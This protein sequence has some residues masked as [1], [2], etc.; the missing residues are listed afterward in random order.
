M[1]LPRLI[2]KPGNVVPAYAATCQQQF[3][4]TEEAHSYLVINVNY[5]CN[6]KLLFFSIPTVSGRRMLKRYDP[7]KNYTPHCPL[8]IQT[9]YVPPGMKEQW[10]RDSPMV[11]TWPP[12]VL[13]KEL[14]PPSLQDALGVSVQHDICYELKT[15]MCLPL[16]IFPNMSFVAVVFFFCH[17]ILSILQLILSCSLGYQTLRNY[18]AV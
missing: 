6:S 15:T 3:Y 13:I 5:L 7:Q 11:N 8:Q 10:M 14:S 1:T 12:D 9:G 18:I 17:Y 4:I 16:V 2:G